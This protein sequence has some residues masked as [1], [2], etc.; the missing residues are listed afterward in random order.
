MATP[1]AGDTGTSRELRLAAIGASVPILRHQLNELLVSL[2]FPT[3]GADSV[4]LAVTEACTN[5]VLHAYPAEMPGDVSMTAHASAGTLMVTVRDW[6]GGFRP[7]C[8]SRGLGLG[9]P[10]IHKIADSVSITHA[11]PGVAV[12]MQFR[13]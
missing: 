11:H 6:G 1:R 8:P 2:K 12:R 13:P 7:G 9:L 3:P 4:R 5:A 10:L